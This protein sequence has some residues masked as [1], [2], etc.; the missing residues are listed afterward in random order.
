MHSL[1]RH[2]LR[3]ILGAL[4]LGAALLVLAAYL[5]MLD[6]MNEVFDENLKQVALAAMTHEDA[7]SY[8]QAREALPGLPRRYE[9]AGEFDF[10]TA[11][12]DRKGTL[13]FSSDPSAALPFARVSG[14]SHDGEGKNEWH[15]YTIVQGD[16]VVQAA[17]RGASRRMLAAESASSLLVPLLILVVLIGVLVVVALRRG[18]RP[19]DAAAGGIA[20]R[21][22]ISL[23]PIG[24][25][26]MPREIHP[27][28]GSINDL[29][30]RLDQAFRVQRRF[31]ADA[32]HE[33]RS[34]VTALRLQMQ[35]LERA[36]D[37]DERAVATREL[38]LGVERVQRLIEQLLDLSRVEPDAPTRALA[39]LDLGE[40]LRGVVAKRSVEAN[41]K[42]LDLGAQAEPGIC[43][44]ADAH[45]L[46][47]LLDNLVGNAIRYTCAG[48][49]ID[50]QA[51]RLAE[52]PT[53]R[54][55]DDGP[56][57]PEHERERVFDRFYRSESL[58]GE[59]RT[60]GSGLG[61]AIVRAI[62]QRHAAVVSLHT[63]ESGRG[64]EARV[65]FGA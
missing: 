63:P 59:A 13:L 54:V 53:L 52:R 45:Q 31:V 32:A 38:R 51:C 60:S 5:A 2:L 8:A 34:P 14:L 9:E 21:S 61:L 47:V 3:W 48:G 20:A 11:V 16:R 58:Q 18:L 65:A 10:V 1:E 64:L 35:L 23:E 50:V 26:G 55:I 24:A 44:Q 27:L 49:R 15:V 36:E 28:I 42:G 12:Y 7:A 17:Q 40:L 43:V 19:L 33:L 29:M 22:A 25:M 62:A 4:A 56:G 30:Q 41:A 37:P 6:E 39:P 46:E 57:I